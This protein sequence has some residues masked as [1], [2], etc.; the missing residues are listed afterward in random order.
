MQVEAHRQDALFTAAA[1]VCAVCTTRFSQYKC[2]RCAAAYCS[3]GCYRA[4]GEHCTEAFYAEQ[5]KTEL[6]ATSVSKQQANQM[7]HTLREFEQHS[8]SSWGQEGE[9][10]SASEEGEDS[11][12][13]FDACKDED[14]KQLLWMLQQAEISEDQLPAALR[15][16][17]HRLRADGSLGAQL[18]AHQAWWEKIPMHSVELTRLGWQ[19]ISEE[20]EKA[21]K[22]AGAPSA[23]IPP[24]LT[25]LTRRQPPASLRFNLIDIV[26]AYCY[27][28]RLYCGTPHDDP[29]PAAEAMLQL[30]G[31]LAGA[32]AGAHG[33][34]EEAL[35]E[36]ALRSEHRQHRK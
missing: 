4:H 28:Y 19:F 12:A 22:E 2:P 17:F 5:A 27:M 33:S 7:M 20:V 3:L 15:T 6:R 10:D 25:Q 26:W 9:D 32:V 34:A 29:I 16:Q 13:E 31:V 1:R 8:L 36:C 35:L 18:Q 30:S 14:V 23:H 21:A 11:N 24:S